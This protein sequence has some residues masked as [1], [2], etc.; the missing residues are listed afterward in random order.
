MTVSILLFGIAR[1][2]AGGRKL[3]LILPDGSDVGALLVELGS[4]YPAFNELSSLMVA[5]NDEYADRSVLL[6]GD[7]EVALIPPVSGG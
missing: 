1:D 2:I 3:Q 5:V 4:Q 7:E 6:T